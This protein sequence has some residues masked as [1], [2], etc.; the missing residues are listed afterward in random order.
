MTTAGAAE[1]LRQG[2]P[3]YAAPQST[4]SGKLEQNSRGRKASSSCSRLNEAA[5]ISVFRGNDQDTLGGSQEKFPICCDGIQPKKFRFGGRCTR[6]AAGHD[7]IANSR[8]VCCL[9]D[10]SI[11]C[12]RKESVSVRE[13]YLFPKAGVC[14]CTG[15]CVQ[16]GTE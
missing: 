13:A 9:F 16:S 11:F 7:G 14:R 2:T 5:A 8:F 6:P 15:S 4:I 3:L 1:N 10:R 12:F